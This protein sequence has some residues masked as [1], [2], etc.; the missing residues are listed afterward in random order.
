MTRKFFLALFAAAAAASGQGL[1]I[2]LKAGKA[3]T[4]L[5][6]AA[7]VP[8]G[9]IAST[10]GNTVIGPTGELH[11][12]FQLSIE[13]DALHRDLGYEFRATPGLGLADRRVSGG[14]WEFPFLAK[15]RLSRLFVSPFA[16]AGVAFNR[17]TGVGSPPELKNSSTSGFVLG[18]GLEGRFPIIRVS[19]DVRFTR[20][21]DDNFRVSS[22][23]TGLSRRNQLE[24]LVGITL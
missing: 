2:G 10:G 19:G 23:G 20:W 14:L 4:D 6:R 12:P 21:S 7:L 15:Y 5:I 22:N 24:F 8:S 13:V 3:T 1:S 18:A 11:L 17:I 9:S 16:E